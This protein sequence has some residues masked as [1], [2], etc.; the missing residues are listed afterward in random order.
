MLFPDQA[1]A[2]VSG[3]KG[4]VGGRTELEIPK[5]A[6]EKIFKKT[7]SIEGSGRAGFESTQ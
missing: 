3:N 4:A 2:V 7:G 1:T 6:Q 5:D